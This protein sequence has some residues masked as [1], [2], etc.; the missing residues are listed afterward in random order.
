M[1]AA[2]K[3]FEA[4]DVVGVMI[5][6]SYRHAETTK[7]FLDFFRKYGL[8]PSEYSTKFVSLEEKLR[9]LEFHYNVF[10]IRRV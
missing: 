10:F 1:Q 8:E 4:V 6:W 9:N 5:E 3:F 7:F 2:D